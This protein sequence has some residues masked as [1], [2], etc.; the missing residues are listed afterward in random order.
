MAQPEI[1]KPKAADVEITLFDK[2]FREQVLSLWTENFENANY[3]I[4]IRDI[5]IA[6]ERHPCLFFIAVQDTQ[7]LGTCI[8]SSDGHRSWIYYLCVDPSARRNGIATCLMERVEKAL[9]NEG[10]TQVGLHTRLHNYSAID[11]YR[12]RGYFLEEAVCFGK[13]L[14]D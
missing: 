1:T 9:V 13:Q 11:F 12:Q 4:F 7:L 6:M 14:E 3:Q 2:S 10:N 5:G 8:G